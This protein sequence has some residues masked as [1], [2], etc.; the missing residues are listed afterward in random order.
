MGDRH[1]PE[2]PPQWSQRFSVVPTGSVSG[3]FPRALMTYL[4][5]V[6]GFDWFVHV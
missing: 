4:V 2:Y 6:Y 5:Y 1:A 3:V